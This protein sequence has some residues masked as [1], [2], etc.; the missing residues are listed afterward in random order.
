MEGMVVEFEAGVLLLPMTTITEEFAVVL[1]A[2]V[3]VV[4][5]GVKAGS[6][7]VFWASSYWKPGGH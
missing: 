3:G 4:V 5:G 7:H 1:G 2:T 6:I